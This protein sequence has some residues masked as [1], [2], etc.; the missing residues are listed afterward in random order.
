MSHA[1]Q[2]LVFQL[3]ISGPLVL[4]VIVYTATRREQ[5]LIQ[6]YLLCLLVLILAWM[7][8]MAAQASADPAVRGAGNL[9]A[10]PPAAFMAP[11]FCLLMLLYARV[12]LFETSRGARWAVL[13]PFWLFLV[14]F[15]TDDWHGLMAAD[16][17]GPGRTARTPGPLFWSFQVCSNAAALVG[18]GV[19]AAVARRTPSPEER[20]RMVLLLAGALVPLLVHLGFTLRVLPFEVPLTPSALGLTSLLLVAAIR[21]YRLLEVQPVAW[22][23]VIEASGDAVILADVDERVVDLNPRAAALLGVAGARLFGEQ[24][25]DALAALGPTEP[26]AI[27]DAL[28]ETVRSGGTA[29]VSEVEDAAGR[30]LEVSVGR[31]TGGS[32]A[33]AGTFVVLRNRTTE[34]RAE[35]LLQR[36]Q[37]LES[38]A[39]LAAGVAH[40]VNNPLAFVRSNLVHLGQVAAE[41]AR[42]V[43]DL[44]KEISD[45]TAD[46]PEVID[47][48][49]TGL[50]RIERI[51]RGLL[52][53]SRTTSERVDRCDL[54]GIVA[55]AAR[56]A[57]LDGDASIRLDSRLAEDLP[58]IQASSDQLTQVL[59]NLFLNAKQALRDRADAAIVAT[60]ARRGAWIEIRVADN[61][62]GVHESIRGKIFD[63]FF[64]T[65]APNEG[66]GLG[67]PIAFDI[68]REHGGTL[69]VAESDTGGACFVVRLPVGR[70]PRSV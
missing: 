44:P 13:A 40:E 15:L 22:R 23:D 41:L 70:T 26:E 33:A 59:L 45:E 43:G 7:V 49:I 47:E 11:V 14:A 25:A 30:I 21:R 17:P 54:N 32:A 58:S 6:R 29:P 12:E 62:P 53:L 18:L 5:G 1:M 24:L 34:R 67:L 4:A 52:D 56:F 20:R 16:M 51:V 61:G 3:G 65:R 2:A 8:G 63:P 35:R 64:T 19:T 50:E 42:R 10:Y 37:R 69:E 66:T 55:E 60:T 31:A 48:S 9:L 28:L 57:S 39:I 46:L 38:I 36:S 27:L 68:V